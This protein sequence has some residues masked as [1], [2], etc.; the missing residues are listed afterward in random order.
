M[1]FLEVTDVNT[2]WKQLQLLNLSNKY[3]EVRIIPIK[4]Y[5]WG[6]EFFIHDPSGILWHIG[7]FYL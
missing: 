4:E 3:P 2:F 7:E 6:K 1:I 5:D